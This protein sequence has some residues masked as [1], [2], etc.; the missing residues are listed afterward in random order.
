MALNKIFSD[1]WDKGG[2]KMK[3]IKLIFWFLKT[4]RSFTGYGYLRMIFKE[5]GIKRAI[6]FIK[7]SNY[8]EKMAKKYGNDA[9]YAMMNRVIEI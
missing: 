6:W 9:W 7:Q 5:H 8:D 2:F 1:V 4:S 3:N